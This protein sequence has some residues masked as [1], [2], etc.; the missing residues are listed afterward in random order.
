MSLL[1]RRLSL[2]QRGPDNRRKVSNSSPLPSTVAAPAS[3]PSHLRQGP[4]PNLSQVGTKSGGKAGRVSHCGPTE[5][6]PARNPAL[7]DATTSHRPPASFSTLP[8]ETK[9]W[10]LQLADADKTMLRNVGG[11]CRAWYNLCRPLRW[12]TLDL[13]NS[14]LETLLF[15]V[16]HVLP[17]HAVH[18]RSIVYDAATSQDLPYKRYTARWDAEKEKMYQAVEEVCD[19]EIGDGA[20]DVRARSL[21]VAEIIRA[22]PHLEAV[23]IYEQALDKYSLEEYDL[24]AALFPVLEALRVVVAS[25]TVLKLDVSPFSAPAIAEVIKQAV[26]LRELRLRQVYR[27]SYGQAVGLVQTAVSR[28]QNIQVLDL[29]YAIPDNVGDRPFLSPVSRLTIEHKAKDYQPFTTLLLFLPNF[30]STLQHL[31][32]HIHF[33]SL[34]ERYRRSSTNARRLPD[35]PVFPSLANA[36]PAASDS[37]P[38]FLPSLTSLTLDLDSLNKYGCSSYEHDSAF[39][40]SPVT[41]ITLRNFPIHKTYR[42]NTD[43]DILLAFLTHHKRRTLR[44]VRVEVKKSMP[45]PVP[46]DVKRWC[47]H[48]GVEYTAA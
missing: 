31:D 5:A 35:F 43:L 21:L 9:L 13:N 27:I 40:S 6:C 33:E 29:D 39:C 28:L 38:P 8:V 3:G 26:N 47:R 30:A 25:L 42:D 34:I 44:S 18:V 23:E 4:S 17:R 7:A 14:T 16:Q 12:Q 19:E 10:I 32:L 48:N 1:V 2:V 37:P 11:T 36:L 46:R 20:P 41:H 24:D 15:F 45:W 22:C